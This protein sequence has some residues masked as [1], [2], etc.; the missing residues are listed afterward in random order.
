MYIN[1]CI[2]K[3]KAR[4]NKQQFIEKYAKARLEFDLFKPTIAFKLLLLG[5]LG[6]IAFLY[7]IL[8]N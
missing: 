1:I 3:K 8:E 4:K 6:S 5:L 7:Q 2:K